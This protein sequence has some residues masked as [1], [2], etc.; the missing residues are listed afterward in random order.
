[1]ATMRVIVPEVWYQTVEIEAESQEEAI[2]KVADGD[3]NYLDDKLEYSH[4][5]D[6]SEFYCVDEMGRAI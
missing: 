1:M 2:R 5:R 6:S 3:G 4:T